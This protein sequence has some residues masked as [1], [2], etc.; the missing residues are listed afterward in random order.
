MD[1]LWSPDPTTDLHDAMQFGR[2]AD[3]TEALSRIVES[4]DASIDKDQVCFSGFDEA[5]TLLD[6]RSVEKEKAC[7]VRWTAEEDDVVQKILNDPNKSKTSW[8]K[9]A[10]IIGGQKNGK[11]I[12]ERWVN[13]IN[14]NLA[15]ACVGNTERQKI[16]DIMRDIG[17]SSP[18]R[19]TKLLNEW[20]KTIGYAGIRSTNEVRNI[21]ST[22]IFREN[23]LTSL[24]DTKIT[25]FSSKHLGRL[26]IPLDSNSE[27]CPS[28]A[29]TNEA[30]SPGEIP[31]TWRKMTISIVPRVTP[32]PEVKMMMKVCLQHD[33]KPDF[34]RCSFKKR[35]K[36]RA[37]IP[38]RMQMHPTGTTRVPGKLSF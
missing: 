15:R 8:T 19:T 23:F 16:A 11:Q 22:K 1:L 3:M 7:R 12:R 35:H 34:Q 17:S 9:I 2:G 4:F 30:P 13:V 32:R 33:T 24:S 37:P 21:C 38:H 36:R 26:P 28:E 5:N 29:T 31:S 25:H 20:R 14:P 6:G 10:H 27:Q 18:S